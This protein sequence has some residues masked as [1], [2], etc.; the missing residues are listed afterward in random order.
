MIS[1]PPPHL[2]PCRTFYHE[3]LATRRC[4]ES[5]SKR[6]REVCET[7]LQKALTATLPPEVFLNLTDAAIARAFEKQRQQWEPLLEPAAASAAGA[8]E[9][10]LAG[11]LGLPALE[12]HAGLQGLLADLVVV[13]QDPYSVAAN[14]LARTQVLKTII[15]GEIV[16]E[17]DAP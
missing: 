4:P 13:D 2:P 15:N 3:F 16:Y 5:G 11:V 9:S 10:E 1:L 12:R 7:Y 14:R 6:Q 17:R 8:A